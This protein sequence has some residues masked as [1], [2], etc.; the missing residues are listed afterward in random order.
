MADPGSGNAPPPPPQTGNGPNKPGNKPTNT[1]GSKL[2]DGLKTFGING[3]ESGLGFVTGLMMGK[4]SVRGAAGAIAALSIVFALEFWFR[5]NAKAKPWLLLAG[6]FVLAAAGIVPYVTMSKAGKGKAKDATR[7]L[8]TTV[9]SWGLVAL[10]YGVVCAMMSGGVVAKADAV[11]GVVLSL[12]YAATTITIGFETGSGHGKSPMTAMAAGTWGA[13]ALF[14][15][16]GVLR[17]KE[18]PIKV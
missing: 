17:D 6:I 1:G 7:V 2:A 9:A 10:M 12:L 18:M 8:P 4:K 14:D 3:V 15:L 16:G 13:L 5:Y 11:Q